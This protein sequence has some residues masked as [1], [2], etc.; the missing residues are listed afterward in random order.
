M[1]EK[2]KKLR[3]IE[4]RSQDW[5]I[6][7]IATEVGVAKQTVVDVC[8]DMKEELSALQA[9]QLDALYEE[10]KIGT[11]AR[12]KNLSSILR[13]IQEELES[14]SLLDVPTEKLVELYL[15]TASTLE[16]AMVEPRFLSSKEQQEAKAT[17]AIIDRL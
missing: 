4:L 6:A 15:K 5:S 17:R 14:R 9:L 3:I 8:N 10:N 16:G 13:K 7:K 11:E 1:V 12:I 2:E